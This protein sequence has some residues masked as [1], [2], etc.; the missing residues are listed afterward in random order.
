FAEECVENAWPPKP[1]RLI[2][3]YVV[4]LD[5][6]ATQRWNSIVSLHIPEIKDL[7][8][9]LK[10]FLLEIS[11]EFKFLIDIIDTEL[12]GIADT[13]PAPYGDEIKGISQASGIPLVIAQD[14]NGKVYHGRNLDFGF[15]LSW[16][17]ITWPLAEKLRTVTIQ[18]NF[19]QNGKLL[20]ETTTFVG[21]V[22]VLTGVKPNVFSVSMNERY[23][24]QG[25]YVGLIEWIFNINRAQSFNT[26]AVRDVLTKSSSY[27]DAVEY[28]SKTVILAPCYYILGGPESGQGIIITRSRKISDYFEML[29]KD[30][31][32]FIIETNYDNWKPQPS[33]DDRLTPAI[34]C[35][36]KY[37][38]QNVTFASLFNVFSSR[39]VLNKSTVYTALI[40]LSTGRLESYLQFCIDS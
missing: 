12:P 6:P 28:L 31:L 19:T 39:P 23:G 11:P 7:I 35:M 14:Q 21:Y 2:K 1:D 27:S 33:G 32:W 24:F 36:K 22:G 5:E 34:R 17:N 25:G 3:T 13:L 20:F 18:V 16:R 29:G 15:P 10:L 4:N 8:D 26:L 30:N 38:L 9:S 37:G 40:E